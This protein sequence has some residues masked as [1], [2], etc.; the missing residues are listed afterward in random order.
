MARKCMGVT[1]TSDARA[2]TEHAV[3]M[4]REMLLR[5]DFK[6]GERLS[7][8]SLLHPLDGDLLIY[9]DLRKRVAQR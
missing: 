4:L 2:Q 9:R 5:G 6:P 7:E 3:L 8:L 1:T